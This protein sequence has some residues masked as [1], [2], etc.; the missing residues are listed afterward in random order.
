[1]IG[2]VWTLAFGFRKRQN[3]GDGSARG[4]Q[5]PAGEQ[6]DENTSGRL[7]KYGRKTQDYGVP[8]RCV[9]KNVHNGL[10]EIGLS[11]PISSADHFYFYSFS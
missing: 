10:H 5:Y 9:R 7:G 4:A 1:M 8:C 3:T 11:L 6:V 2:V